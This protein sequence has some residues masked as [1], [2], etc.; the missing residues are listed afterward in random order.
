MKSK[1]TS[2][3]ITYHLELNE[4]DAHWLRTL[5]QNPIGV[6]D[7]NPAHEDPVDSMYR[8]MFWDALCVQPVP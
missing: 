1:I 4:E 2:T 7:G 5:M 3:E 8:K 6:A